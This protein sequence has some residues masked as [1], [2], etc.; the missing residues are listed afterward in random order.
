LSFVDSLQETNT[1]V[2]AIILKNLK[3]FLR[4]IIIKTFIF[5]L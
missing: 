5:L 4:F 3:I 2:K 1:L